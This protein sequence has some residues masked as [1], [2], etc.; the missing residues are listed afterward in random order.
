M[1]RT[2]KRLR[3]ARETLQHLSPAELRHAVGGTL[4]VTSLL[5]TTWGAVVPKLDT[6]PQSG[7]CA[8]SGG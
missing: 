6:Q 1:K 7:G 4:A 2:P 5:A 8:I 3:L